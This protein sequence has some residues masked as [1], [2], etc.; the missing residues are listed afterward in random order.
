VHAD[1]KE[2]AGIWTELSAIPEAA[3]GNRKDGEKQ[4][5]A[6]LGFDP[7]SEAL[8]ALAGISMAMSER[9]KLI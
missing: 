5:A 6:G 2:Y 9:D 4:A 8:R 1:A 7:D 3:F